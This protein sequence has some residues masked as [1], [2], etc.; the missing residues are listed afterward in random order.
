MRFY[1]YNFL[2]FLN[3]ILPQETL[4]KMKRECAGEGG[5]G[6]YH[7]MSHEVG[8]GSKLSQKSAMF[9]LNGP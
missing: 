3:E 4:K 8:S 1:F 9:Y 2:A 7:Q 5:A 6:D